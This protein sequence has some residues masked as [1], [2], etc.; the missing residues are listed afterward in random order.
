MTLRV[1][2]ALEDDRAAVDRMARGDAAAVADLYDT[3]KTRM[4]TGL[5]KL[6]ELLHG[7]LGEATP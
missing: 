1:P 2:P 3:I 6:R 5:L 4:R 7:S